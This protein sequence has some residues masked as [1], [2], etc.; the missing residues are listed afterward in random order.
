MPHLPQSLTDL[1]LFMYAKISAL[2]VRFVHQTQQLLISTAFEDWADVE[3]MLLN[4]FETPYAD[5]GVAL[6][7]GYGQ[8]RQI[9]NGS[10]WSTFRWTEIDVFTLIEGWSGLRK[11]RAFDP[12]L[13]T[14]AQCK[15]RFYHG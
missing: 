11:Q 14:C 12:E 2:C 8:R 9:I 6:Q 4:T 5:Y 3:R 15:D 10:N 13:C 7:K 1:V